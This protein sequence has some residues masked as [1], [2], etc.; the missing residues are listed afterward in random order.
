MPLYKKKL[1]IIDNVVDFVLYSISVSC[2][3]KDLKIK[4]HAK[5]RFKLLK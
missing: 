4:T 3:A 2:R 5:M 1:L